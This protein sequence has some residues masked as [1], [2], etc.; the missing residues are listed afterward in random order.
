MDN[1]DQLYRDY[2]IRPTEYRRDYGA[3]LS[4][5]DWVFHHKDMD[6]DPERLSCTYGFAQD[7]EDCK[8]GIDD[9]IDLHPTI[10]SPSNAEGE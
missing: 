6:D 10:P 2:I 7:I 1:T 9:M 4:A 5:C 8:K 3:W